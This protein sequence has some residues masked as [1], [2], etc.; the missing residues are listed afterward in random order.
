MQRMTQLFRDLTDLSPSIS[1][2]LLHNAGEALYLMSS[3]LQPLHADSAGFPS[4]EA[5]VQDAFVRSLQSA[6]RRLD[7][8]CSSDHV[9]GVVTDLVVVVARLWQF[10]L[11]L[12]GAWT[13]RLRE[14][15]PDVLTKIIR[16]AAVSTRLGSMCNF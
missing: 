13:P 4:L 6:T 10:D 12:P 5:D 7:D 14:A 15:A 3:I 9:P 16:L 2:P 1:Q 11:C 8:F